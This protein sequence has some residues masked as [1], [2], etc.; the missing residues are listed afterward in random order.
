[1]L[2]YIYQKFY[3][4]WLFEDNKISDYIGVY[5]VLIIDLKI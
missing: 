4:K 2:I 1:M 5:Q 3:I